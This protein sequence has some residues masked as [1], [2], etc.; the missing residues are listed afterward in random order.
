MKSFVTGGTGFIGGHVVRKL[1]ARGDDVVALVR[2]PQKAGELRALGCELV[3]GDLSD[4]D[5]LR[6]AMEGCAS[7]FHVAAMYKAGIPKSE[8]PK[9]HEAN[10]AGT[11]KTLD[12]AIEAGIPKIVYVSTVGY[13][14]N[15]RGQ[16]VDETYQRTPGDWLSCYDETK[17]LAHEIAKDRI[18]NGAPVVIAQPGGVYGPGDP[19]DAAQ[20]VKQMATGRIRF[21]S[22]PDSGFNFG[23]IDDIAEGIILVQDKGRIGESYVLGGEITTLGE[24]VKKVSRLAGRKPP[25]T[26]PGFMVKASIPIGPLVTKIMGFPP[27]LREL[28]KTSDGVTFWASDAKAREE[29]GYSPRKLDEGLPETVA[30]FA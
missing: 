24:L 15:T 14:G 10:V 26:M 25:P 6:A 16:V 17:Y 13:F 4:Q 7:V 12:A 22:F 9:M 11:A 30:A 27:N 23:H 8:C 21:L 29:L 2:S 18:K 20:I 28:I 3:E 19:S 1:R 5:R